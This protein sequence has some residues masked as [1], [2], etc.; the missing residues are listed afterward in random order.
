MSASCS[1]A[2][3]LQTSKSA[4]DRAQGSPA[5]DLADIFC[6]LARRTIQDRFRSLFRNDDV[7]VYRTAQRV[8]S[9]EL[10]WL[11]EGLIRDE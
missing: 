6:R 7:A 1:R 5:K 10:V 4:E 8:L 2:Q 11:E 3:M 9:N